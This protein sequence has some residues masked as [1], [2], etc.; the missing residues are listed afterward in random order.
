MDPVWRQLPNDLVRRVLEFS[1]EIEQRV[2]FKIRPRRLVVPRNFE[3]RS[4][5]VYD[6][7]TRTMWDF[8]GLTEQEHPYWI[9]RKGIK[10]SQYRSPDDLHVFNMGW[11][12]Y[13]MTM[14]SGTQQ[15]GPTTCSNHLVFSNKRVKFR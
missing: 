12:D 7:L 2:A 10:F 13:Q 8:T 14:F 5:I 1:D 6:H 9:L 4:E 11:E 3:F 15:V